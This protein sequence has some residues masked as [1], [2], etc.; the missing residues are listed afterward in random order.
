MSMFVNVLGME[1]TKEQMK[2]ATDD[3]SQA[4]FI[5]KGG[6]STV[7]QG[8]INCTLVAVKVLNEVCC[9]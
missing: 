5:G 6:Y 2:H 1:F 3:F 9:Q 8:Y 7:Y 4:R